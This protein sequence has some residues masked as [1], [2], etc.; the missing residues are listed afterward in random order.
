MPSNLRIVDYSYGFTGSAHDATTFEYTA[1][2]RHPDWLFK[3][4]EFAWTDSAYS[5][6]PRTIPVHK[7]PASLQRQNTIFDHMVSHV[8]VRSEHCMGA[9]KGRFQC[10]RGLRVSINTPA[11]HLRALRWIKVAIILHNLIIDVEG[12]ASGQ[13]FRSVHTA[14]EED[15]DSGA[16][17]EDTD[18][19][20]EN[21][22]GEAKRRCLIAEL[23]EFRYQRTFN[24]DFM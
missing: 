2:A 13:Y 24:A 18:A 4:E 12:Q 9:L 8:R 5:L 11:E 15:E 22:D 6:T 20:Q 23:L 19:D 16:V 17:D 1:A 14:D 3:G 21:D 10:L 7:K